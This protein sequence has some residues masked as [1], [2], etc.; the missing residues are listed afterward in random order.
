MRAGGVDGGRGKESEP[1]GDESV[2]AGTAGA[3]G[4]DTEEEDVGDWVCEAGGDM[5]MD[6]TD[7][8]WG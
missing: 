7:G 1:D 3:D 8:D 4:W 6:T 5:D 2:I